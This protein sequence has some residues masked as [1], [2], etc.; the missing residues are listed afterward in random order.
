[1]ELRNAQIDPRLPL[2]VGGSKTLQHRYLMALQECVGS[3][4]ILH[5]PEESAKHAVWKGQSMMVGN[6]SYNISQ[7]FSKI[8]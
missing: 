7:T 5:I 4:K 6:R 8:L 3:T 1:M 2:V